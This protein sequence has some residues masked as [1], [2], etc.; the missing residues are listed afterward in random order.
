MRLSIRS[1][2]RWLAEGHDCISEKLAGEIDAFRDEIRNGVLDS[3]DI[4]RIEGAS[5]AA[6]RADGLDCAVCFLPGERYREFV[7]AI[8]G[9]WNLQVV[10]RHGWP[11][12]SVASGPATVADAAGES[13]LGGEG[14]AQ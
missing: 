3:G 9:E 7:A 5:A 2:A 4:V 10:D 1:V 13:I 11:V 8:A 12:L 6:A 14:A